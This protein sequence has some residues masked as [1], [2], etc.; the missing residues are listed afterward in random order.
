MHPKKKNYG[1]MPEETL[2]DSRLRRS[3]HHSQRISF[4]PS[5]EFVTTLALLEVDLPPV[6][7][8]PCRSL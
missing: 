1:D 3:K 6:Q 5:P 4:N 7:I 8:Y 2:I